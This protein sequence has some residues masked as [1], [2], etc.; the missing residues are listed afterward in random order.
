MTSFAVIQHDIKEAMKAKDNGVRDALR[1]LLSNLKNYAIELHKSPEDLTAD[2]VLV[3]L[4]REIKKRKEAITLFTDGGRAE[5]AAQE[6]AELAVFERYMPEQLSEAEI[7]TIA[8]EV[9]ADFDEATQ[10]QFGQI[11]GA[12]MKKTAGKADGSLV[13]QV[14]TQ[15]LD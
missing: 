12:V 15:L 4:K 2:E 6:S 8:K 10:K 3:I 13:Q 7:V 1:L 14:V 9:I 5:Q 11:M